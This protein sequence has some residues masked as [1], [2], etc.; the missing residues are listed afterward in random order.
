[1]AIAK[2]GSRR[3]AANT[4]TA[5]SVLHAM[6]TPTT[7][8]AALTGA[9]VCTSCLHRLS[10]QS[11]HYA[12]AAAAFAATSETTQQEAP[13]RPVTQTGPRKAFR[14]SASPVISRPPLLTRELTSFEK[15]YFLY[16]KRL[17]ERLALPFTRYFYYKKGTPTDEERKRK[18]EARTTAARDIGMYSGYGETAW[19][20][21]VLVGDKTGEPENQV[22]ALI[23]DAEGKEVMDAKPVGDSEADEQKISGNEKEGE[24]T[25]K[26]IGQ[27]IAIERPAPRRTQ[28]DEENDVRSL[29]RKLDRS[30]YFVVKGKDGHWR[31]PEDLVYGRENLQ[32]VGRS[33]MLKMHS[34]LT[35]RTG[36][37]A[38]NHPIMRHQHEYMD[39]RQPPDRSLH[40]RLR[41]TADEQSPS[42]SPRVDIDGGI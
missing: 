12:A 10:R 7:R 22:K 14:L 23:M 35:K 16:Q 38:H 4:N 15:A 9:N 8:P 41:A 25:G 30:L 28:A 42:Q 2:Q 19:N 1:M 40:A 29:N 36:S 13:V 27:S 32:Q 5:Y 20:D 31:F 34:L 11:R 21:E 17:N 6:T 33:Q 37:R 39:G 18:Q 26:T 24:G 3:L